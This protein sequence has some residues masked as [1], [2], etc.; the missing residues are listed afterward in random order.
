MF[1]KPRRATQGAVAIAA[2]SALALTGCDDGEARTDLRPEGPPDVLAVLVLNDSVNG[3]VEAATY[4]KPNDEKRPVL[5]GLPDFTT[6]TLCPDDGTAV[7]MA[8]DAAPDSFYVRIMFD[9][10]LDPTVEDL[11]P[12]L[13]DDGLETGSFTGTLANTQ[14]VTLECTGVDGTMQELAYDGYYSPSGNAVTW[15]VGPSLVIKQAGDVIVPT[16]SLCQVTLKANIHDKQGNEIPADQR[17]PF[18]FKVSGLKPLVLDPGDDTEV[19]AFQIYS[20]NWYSQFNGEIQVPSI[21]TDDGNGLGFFGLP[22]T[23]AAVCSTADPIAF[24][25]SP[26]PGL[27]GICALDF[28]SCQTNADCDQTGGANTCDFFYAYSLFPF[29]LS[30][31]EFAYG[32]VLPVETEKEYTFTF[33]QGTMLKDKCGAVTTLGA[34]SVEAGTQATVKT[35]P[36]AL[37]ATLLSINNNDVPPA[38]RKMRLPFTNVVD[39]TSIDPA[40]EVTMTPATFLNATTPLTPAQMISTSTEGDIFIRGFYQPNTEYT[41]TMKGGATIADAYGKVYTHPAD[42]VIKFKTQPIAITASAP[43]N[44][45]AV[46]KAAPTSFT[47]VTMT[48][49]Q[50]MDPTTL[51]ADDFTITAAAGG[52]VPTLTIDAN[53]GSRATNCTNTSTGCQLRV[54]GVYA[55][56]EYT[57]TLKAGA[58]I[59][60]R[61][62]NDYTQTADRVIKFTVSEAEPSPVIPCLGA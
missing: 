25:I 57:F 47:R 17:G 62:G 48:F 45:A 38:N 61:L 29:G 30:R 60:D 23:F 3:L 34:P 27:G 9:E 37:K 8:E 28:E 5:V 32:P 13:D 33:K 58:V 46:V 52:T 24:D 4:C 19:D 2:I 15:P 42:T 50:D 59:K 49:N 22:P 55:P 11:I 56:G 1:L 14:P 7:P 31:Q 26:K 21:C 53:G 43:A 40:T 44:G 54:N 10:L 16:N 6:T 39:L 35:N 18:K 41:F 20:D 12:I 51:T 36:W